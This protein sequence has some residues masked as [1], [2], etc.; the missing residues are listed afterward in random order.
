MNKKD[1]AV[2][3]L[4][5]IVTLKGNEEKEVLARIDTGATKSSMDL[6]LASELGLGPVVDSKLVKSAHGSKLRPVIEVD[7]EIKGEELEA[8]FTLADRE[9]MKF[10]VLIGQNVLKNGFLVDPSIS[11]GEE[12][13]KEREKE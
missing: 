5:E 9:H 8:L 7:M 6:S 12:E 3:G 1:K 4:T 13:M 11:P 10:E 2:L